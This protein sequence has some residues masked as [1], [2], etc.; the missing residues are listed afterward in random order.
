MTFIK[1]TELKGIVPLTK[2]TVLT[3]RFDRALL[4]ATHVHGGQV[5]K[6]TSIPYVAHL[7][8]VAATVLE[9]G[10]DEDLAIAA[11]LHDSVEDQGGKARLDDVRNRF[12]NRVARIVEACSD[13]LADT[14]KGERKADWR[15]RKEAYLAHLRTADE[16]ILWVSLA[17]KVHNAR[18]ILR[19]LRK[20]DIGEKVWVRFSVDKEQTLW[21]YHS[22]AQIFCEKLSNQLADELREI[23][24]VLQT[25]AGTSRRSA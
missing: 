6:E 14:G 16:D 19:D 2:A 5:R 21:Y 15:P 13:S 8:A 23:V 11:L 1:R 17:D 12:G 20:P 10:G 25:E 4:Y 9:Y 7:L 22:L 24:E 3:D 18:S